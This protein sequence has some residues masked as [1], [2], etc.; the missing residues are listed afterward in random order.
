M[1]IFYSHR[2]FRPK[3]KRLVSIFSKH[4]FFYLN[5]VHF[6][7]NINLVGRLSGYSGRGH[8]GNDKMKY[9]DG[10]I[11]LKHKKIKKQ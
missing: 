1:P 5:H 9:V 3:K 8:M 10:H 6:P 2:H 7:S 4:F 11:G